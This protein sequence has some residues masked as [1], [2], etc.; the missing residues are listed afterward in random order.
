MADKC[1]H[2]QRRFVC[3][4]R[5]CGRD[6]W[7]GNDWSFA[8]QLR[9][10]EKKVAAVCSDPVFSDRDDVV[11]IHRRAA[12]SDQLV[13]VRAPFMGSQR[14]KTLFALQMGTSAA[15]FCVGEPAW[16]FCFGDHDADFGRSVLV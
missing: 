2:C 14:G 9:Y 16:Q 8:Y 15:F 13:P 7:V 3:Y 4:L 6:F 1:P 11:F 5:W 10:G 12:A